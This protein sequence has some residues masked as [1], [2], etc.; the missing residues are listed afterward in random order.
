MTLTKFL[1]LKDVKIKFQEFFPKPQFK[2]KKPLLASPITPNYSLVGTAFDYLLR[3]LL[4]SSYSY[5]KSIH[6]IA[7][8]SLKLLELLIKA[9][10]EPIQTKLPIDLDQICFRLFHSIDNDFKAKN[11]N[12]YSNLRIEKKQM[13]KSLRDKIIINI[14]LYSLSFCLLMILSFNLLSSMRFQLY[15]KL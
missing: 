7:E 3:F 9:T 14:F 2:I 10:Q 5:V 1:K 6:W 11:D 15:I 12:E 8:T 4:E 13:T